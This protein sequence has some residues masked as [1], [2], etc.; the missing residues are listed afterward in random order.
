MLR[1]KAKCPPSVCIL[2]SR[3]FFEKDSV[4]LSVF[5]VDSTVSGLR[6]KTKFWNQNKLSGIGAKKC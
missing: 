1:T 2:F 6:V 4:K 5:F 3:V